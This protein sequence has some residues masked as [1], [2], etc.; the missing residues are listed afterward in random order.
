LE[1]HL[2]DKMEGAPEKQV[3]VNMPQADNKIQSIAK[4]EF[5]VYEAQGWQFHHSVTGMS[6]EKEMD[7]ISDKVGIMGLPEVFY[8]FNHLYISSKEHNIVLDFNAID[9]LSYSGHNKRE[10]FLHK[11]GKNNFVKPAKG[12][13]A[14]EITEGLDKLMLEQSG[15]A[16]TEKDLN[17]IDVIPASIRVE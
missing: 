15:L 13:D 3:K 9:S 17:L 7:Q 1:N 11:D 14:E 2:K 16:Q 10:Q 8:G 6:S 12:D 4:I 5:Q